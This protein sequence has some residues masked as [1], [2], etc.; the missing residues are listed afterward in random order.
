M[1]SPKQRVTPT[2]DYVP[3]RRMAP[4]PPR[5]EGFWSPRKWKLYLLAVWVAGTAFWVPVCA[6]RNHMS[7]VWDTYSL[8]WHYEKAIINS[9]DRTY[10]RKGYTKAEAQL[11]TADPYLWTFF[12]QGIAAPLMLLAGGAWLLR[13]A[14]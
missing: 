8:Y 13:N 4:P 3:R 2:L 5:P 1:D 6:E 11:S 12:F 7:Y 14:R 10:V 9:T